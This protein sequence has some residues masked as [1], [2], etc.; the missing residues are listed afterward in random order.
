MEKEDRWFLVKISLFFSIWILFLSVI[1]YLTADKFY[2]NEYFFYYAI[3]ITVMVSLAGGYILALVF[4]NP[5]LKT[6]KF[7]DKLLKDTL[8]EL[9]IPVATIKANAQMIKMSPDSPKNIKRIDRIE[10][11]TDDLLALYKGMDY[12]IKSEIRQVDKENFDL[13]DICGESIKKF[14]EISGNIEIKSNLQEVFVRA[15]KMGFSKI[16]DNLISNAIKY[17][18]PGGYVEVI[19]KEDYLIIKDNG[20]GMN[21]NEVFNVFDRHYQVDHNKS[22]YGIGLSIVKSYCDKEKIYI[23]IDSE[24]GVGSIF[25]LN[26]KNIKLKSDK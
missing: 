20:V 11:A 26:L 6:N 15:D 16:L 7:L 1:I 19:L 25:K 8:H 4:L 23:N 3:S 9:N 18:K 12:Y 21:S 14:K 17:N 10:R 24:K 22:G 5:L 2:K 13:T